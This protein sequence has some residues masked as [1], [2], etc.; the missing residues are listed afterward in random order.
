MDVQLEK[1]IRDY[2]ETDFEKELFDAVIKNLNSPNKLSFNN[3]SY[4]L[5]ELIR[6]YLSRIA[7]DDEI[8]NSCWY[9]EVKNDKGNVIITRKQRMGF[10]VHKWLSPEFVKDELC[11]DTT[12]AIKNLL[13]DIDELNKYTHI[14]EET[15]GIEDAVKTM[16]S[17]DVLNDLLEFF[18]HIK[19]C[20]T[21]VVN[22]IIKYIENELSNQFSIETF[23]E[24]DILS[25]HS[26]IDG[27]EIQKYTF[28]NYYDY[29]DLEELK[30]VVEGEVTAILQYGSDFDVKRDDGY[31]AKM[32]FPFK[33]N[34]KAF[35]KC[36]SGK[37]EYSEPEIKIDNN[38]FFE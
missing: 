38:A 18:M 11:M 12:D 5:R 21:T 20:R 23:N 36:R 37:I 22:H 32:N 4:S 13:K 1:Q 14:S 28:D 34:M 15:F 6:N 3:F 10:A 19:E 31:E 30:F 29:G 7:P 27:Y 33:A 2:F 16:E 17:F 24:I 35:L 26:K 8:K 9:E 25:T